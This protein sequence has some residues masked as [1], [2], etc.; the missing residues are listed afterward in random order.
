MVKEDKFGE[1]ERES[2]GKRR[3]GIE[4]EMKSLD[5]K[6]EGGWEEGTEKGKER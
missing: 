1:K 6:R 2:E 4:E 5:R 3:R